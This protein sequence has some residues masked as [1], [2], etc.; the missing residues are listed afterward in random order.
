AL[1]RF[2]ADSFSAGL[3]GESYRVEDLRVPGAAAEVAGEGLAD[4]V[5]ARSR[6]PIEQVGSGDHEPRRAEAA[7]HSTR[8]DERLL[9]A[10]QVLAPPHPLAGRH[11]V[12][13]RLRAE[14]EAA[15]DDPAVEEHRAGTALALL[16]RILRARQAEPLA[17][18]E[19]QALA[20]PH[21]GLEALAVY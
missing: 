10:M 1:C 19:Q 16:A 9:D 5:V 13:F 17:Q 3:G 12:P 8:L 20:R 2:R 15:T 4:L 14:H 6:V 7:L 18:D 21:V 11:L